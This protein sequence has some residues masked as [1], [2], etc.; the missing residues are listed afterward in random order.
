[1]IGWASGMVRS[2]LVR[3]G[4]GWKAGELA[5]NRSAGKERAAASSSRSAGWPT[6]WSGSVAA[7]RAA[8]VVI[9]P[10]AIRRV[11]KGRTR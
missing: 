3:F 9:E 6:P 10:D 11:R 2:G 7:L 5:E 4:M 1:V 8:G